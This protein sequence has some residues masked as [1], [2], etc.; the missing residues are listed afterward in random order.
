MFKV[1]K[2]ELPWNITAEEI[3]EYAEQAAIRRKLEIES[4]KGTAEEYIDSPEY[5]S[6]FIDHLLNFR[7]LDVED[8]FFDRHPKRGASDVSG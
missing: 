5:N 8:D 2:A 3:R 7:K 6:R 1:I 4:R